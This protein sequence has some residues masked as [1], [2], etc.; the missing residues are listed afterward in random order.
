[1][2]IENEEDDIEV[3]NEGQETAHQAAD[4]DND[5]DNDELPGDDTS[6]AHDYSDATQEE[7]IESEN[8]QPVQS[9]RRLT[10]HIASAVD[11][12]NI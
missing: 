9:K 10:R 8:E 4:E 3:G 1:M 5:T 12:L 2:D 11:E 6:A 7:Q